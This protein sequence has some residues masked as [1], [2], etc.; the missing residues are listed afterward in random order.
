MTFDLWNE[1]EDVNEEKESLELEGY[2]VN[3]LIKDSMI[4]FVSKIDL[5]QRPEFSNFLG[6]KEE[7]RSDSFY[8]ET[9][10]GPI[11]A[12]VLRVVLTGIKNIH[13]D[14][15]DIKELTKA[16]DTIE[17]PK[18]TLS[19]DRRHVL[20]KTPNLKV[21][22]DLLAKLNAYPTQIG[23]KVDLKRVIDLEILAQ[24]ET[25]KFPKIIFDKEVLQLTREP[26]VGFDGTLDSLKN[27]PISSLNVIQTNSQ[28]MKALKNSR[29]TLEEK[30]K[31]FGIE[32]LHDLLFWLPRR[33]IDKSQPQRIRDLL[34]GETATIVGKITQ[35]SEMSNNLGISFYVETD[36][37][38]TIRVTFFRQNWLKVKFKKD[39]VVLV[40]GKYDTWKGKP[41]LSGSSIEHAAEA[42][43]LPIVPIYKQSESRGI[44]TYLLL[45][46]NRELISRIGSLELPPYF[47]QHGRMSYYDALNALHFPE[48]FAQ[49]LEAIESLAYYELVYMQII[50]QETREKSVGR[51]GISQK[52]TS[53]DLQ[54]S[55]VRRLQFELT[56]SQKNAMRELNSKLESINPSSSLLSAEVGSGKT[57]IAQLACLRSVES[58]HQ[59]VLLGPTD[60]LSRQLFAT[61]EKLVSTLDE[62]VK[63]RYFGGGMKVKERKDLLKDIAS[64]EVDIIVG[65]HS[66]MSDS[67]EYSNLGLVCIDEQQ[68]FGAEQ[69]TKL[70]NS[71]P[72]GRIPDL[73]MMSATPIP[74]SVAQVI[75]GDMD[76]LQLKEKPPGRLPIITEWIK[77]DPVLITKEQILPLWSDIIKEAD[78]GNQTFIITP[79]VN[80]S[81]KIDAASVEQTFKHVTEHS[82]QGLR[83]SYVHGQMKQDEQKERMQ[84]FRD[85]KFDVMIASTVV[86]V[87]VDIPDATRVII[88]SAERLGASSL[89]QIRGRVGRNSKQSKCYLVSLG[90]NEQSEKRLQSLVDSDN[91]F[92]IAKIDLELRGEGKIFNTEQSGR[93][94]MI[95]ASL[96]KHAERIEEAKNEAKRILSSPF[97]PLAI[98]DAVA[99]FN[100]KERL[101]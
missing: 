52:R 56:N 79:L 54:F 18:A 44:T 64:G 61:L 4:C 12:F 57:I 33:Y 71:R 70:L 37:N 30:I 45:A 85:K 95:F 20:V 13:I 94:E 50:M 3:V 99:K 14:E 35:I 10:F 26:I 62:E 9:R 25:L 75:Y 23:Y 58:G 91:G 84:Q 8:Y 86:E 96:A 32:T 46:A 101:I 39:D 49:H 92:D 2:T 55:A 48:T 36:I 5:S 89:H 60:I 59:A 100:S 66:V 76:M 15:K 22:K 24:T 28:T 78:K 7:E 87:G 65:T 80:E 27:I 43:I 40:T 81:D 17:L 38:E 6:I 47:R 19:D 68:K 41:Q 53:R 90:N 51:Q 83:V 1:K 98:K 97:K 21:Y 69:R 77:E 73:L 11:N 72:D 16:A 29:K 31:D 63:I 34:E 82:L 67:V 74:R 88:L 93:S 42:A